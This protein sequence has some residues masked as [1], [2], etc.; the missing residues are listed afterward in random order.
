ME[1]DDSCS[2]NCSHKYFKSIMPD[3]IQLVLSPNK[4]HTKKIKESYLFVSLTLNQLL[5]SNHKVENNLFCLFP[6]CSN[7]KAF[8]IFYL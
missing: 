4:T 7:F 2:F 8:K 1:T 6:F 5:L 3:T